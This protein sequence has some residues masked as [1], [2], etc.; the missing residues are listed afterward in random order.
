MSFGGFGS[1]VREFVRGVTL[2]EEVLTG[3]VV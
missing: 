2:V 3:G 1:K